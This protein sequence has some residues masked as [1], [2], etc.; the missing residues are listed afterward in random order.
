MSDHPGARRDGGLSNVRFVLTTP[1]V[2]SATRHCHFTNLCYLVPQPDSVN[3]GTF[4]FVYKKTSRVIG[5]DFQ[6]E[7]LLHFLDLSSVPHHT[8]L[9]MEVE[10]VL[11]V[12]VLNISS[13]NLPRQDIEYPVFIMQRLVHENLAHVLLD[14]LL[15]LF[16]TYERLCLGNIRKCTKALHLLLLDRPT[17]RDDFQSGFITRDRLT[18]DTLHCFDSA[19]AG[20]AKSAHFYDYGLT[21]ELPQGS[22][23]GNPGVDLDGGDIRRFA[24]FIR[25]SFHQMATDDSIS[26]TDRERF[27]CKNSNT[28]GILLIRKRNRRI[29]NELEVLKAMS[30]ALGSQDIRS[31]SLED[32]SLVEIICLVSQANLLVSVH[33]ALLS[34]LLFLPV[35]SAVVEIFPYAINAS[36]PG[37]DV[38][39]T[40]ATLP[41]MN[42]SYR[43]WENSFRENSEPPEQSAHSFD[44]G[45]AHLGVEEQQR[46]K[47]VKEKVPLVPCCHNPELKYWLYQNTRVDIP[48]FYQTLVSAVR[49]SAIN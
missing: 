32:N 27:T 31:V 4:I 15:P 24:N 37:L 10:V 22:M 18:E 39:R 48:S 49:R 34:T 33:G 16:V 25:E 43:A 19:K 17:P 46:I 7:N 13:V 38:Y 42:L 26:A 44:G 11:P 2:S 5:V 41:K 3:A 21:S 23:L 40:L 9:E 12:P 20:L 36:Q 14:D 6:K 29:L 47:E 45:I 30:D 1:R 35:D 8:R 28:S